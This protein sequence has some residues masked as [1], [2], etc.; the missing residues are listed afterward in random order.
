MGYFIRNGG[1]DDKM[2]NDKKINMTQEQ[3]EEFKQN[4]QNKIIEFAK[5]LEN[6]LANN[7]IIAQKKKLFS[8]KFTQDNINKYLENPQNYE[9]QLRQ[10]STVLMTLS[11]QYTSILNYFISMCRFNAIVIPNA[12]KYSS[13][14]GQYDL[15]KLRKDYEKAIQ[16]L[17]KL[18]Y[19]HEFL[20]IVEVC[21]KEDIFYG[22]EV[23]S[24]DSYFIR[25]LDADYCKITS[26]VD[27][28]FCF[29][30]DMSYFDKFKEL[31]GIEGTVLETFPPEFTAMYNAYKKNSDLRWQELDHATTICIKWN[32]SL[33]FVF[34]PFA[35]LY[36]DIADLKKY[37]NLNLEKS[38]IDN[39][40]LIGLKIP[41]VSKP[42]KPD[43]FAI[44]INTAL[45]FYN[46]ICANLPNGVGAFLTPTEI[47]AISFNGSNVSN[48]NDIAEAENNLYSSSGVAAINFG[49][50]VSTSGTAE[51]SNAIDSNRLLKLYV[52]L[53]RWLNKKFKL[54]Y[55]GKFS[56]ELMKVTENNIAEVK[57]T[58]LTACQYGVPCKLQL[59]ALMDIPQSHEQGLA[60]LENEIYNFTENWK[61]LSSSFTSS[62]KENSG[63]STNKGGRPKTE[64]PSDETDEKR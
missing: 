27:G 14:E 20:K 22:L 30:F 54:L 52:Q 56:V 26:I 36:E 50:G 1:D 5:K 64:K 7:E 38:E 25:Q 45:T 47:E 11:P 33:P 32:E 3:Y 60:L 57:A 46:L 9:Q 16:Q 23:E 40:K 59:L 19:Q 4:Y 61:P 24:K 42:T 17:D 62:G 2:E 31:K 18:N 34:P 41:T 15:E 6:T 8:T 28:C 63:D 10:L 58:Y 35:G 13:K 29:S 51:I 39:Y 21:I 55:N 12:T 53:E 48:I 49:K 37:K 44:D 43:E